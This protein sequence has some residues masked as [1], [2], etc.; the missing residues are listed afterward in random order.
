[1]DFVG[2]QRAEFR[3]DLRLRALTG[4]P[5]RRL[6]DVLP[7]PPLPAGC[8]LQLDDVVTEMVLDNVR[9]AI[10]VSWKDLAADLRSM[11][12]ASLAEFLAETGHELE[13]LY[14]SGKGGWTELRRR[15]QGRSAPEDDADR[16]LGRAIGR[17]LHVDDPVRLAYLREGVMEDPRL[18]AMLHVALVGGDVPFDSGDTVLQLLDAHPERR[19]ELREVASVLEERMHRV[20]HAAGGLPLRVHARYTKNEALAAF[21]IDRPGNVREGVK[22]VPE[23]G[24]D[25]FFVTLRKTEGFSPTNMYNDRAISP[26]LFHWESQ[27]TTRT[28]SA[29]GQRYV[30][31][32]STV[33]LF[34]RETKTPD[35]SL[36]APPFLYAGTMTFVSSEGDRPMQILWELD[37][38]LPADVFH[39]ASLLTT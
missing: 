11:P 38:P 35:G 31:G 27:S 13:D 22:W 8:H 32:G 29:T 37:R 34:L 30:T 2:H 18:L 28:G 26:T 9:R 39:Q 16:K 17:L 25:V 15:A 6:P 21:G 5:R 20:T 24:A 1:L 23:A 33:H 14:R 19:E 7:N 3:F 4:V 10:R 36:G 12:E